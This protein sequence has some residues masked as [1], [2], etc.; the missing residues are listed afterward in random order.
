MKQQDIDSTI[1]EVVKGI[2]ESY[3]ILLEKYG[4]L[5]RKKCREDNYHHFK[6]LDTAYTLK[7]E[8]IFIDY[9][10]WLNNILTSR[11]MKEDHIIDNFERISHALEPFT[12]HDEAVY[13][14]KLLS[15]AIMKLEDRKK[16]VE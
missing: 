9:T 14:K 12:D 15:L 16:K 10:L 7:E 2:Y 6:H 4:E 13:Y 3:P 5:G 1:E 8:K 11:G